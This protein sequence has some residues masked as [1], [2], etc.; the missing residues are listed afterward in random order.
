MNRITLNSLSVCA[1]LAA[2]TSPQHAFAQ[3]DVAGASPN[4]LLLVDT[5]GSMEYLTSTATPPVCDP[6]SAV[7][8]QK[9]RWVNLVEVLT[10]SINDYRCV[11]ID[12]ASS[13]FVSTFSLA[14]N[15]PADY[16]YS[17]PYHQP[18]SGNCVAGPGTI[19]L[20]NNAFAISDGAGGTR[21]GFHQYGN[22][23]SCTFSQNTSDGLLS[24]YSSNVRFGLMTFD[25]STN[26]G[27]GFS[28]QAANYTTGIAGTWSY[29]VNNP[30]QGRPGGCPTLV[31]YEVGARNAAA[32]PWEGRMVAFGDPSPNSS[33]P[34]DNPTARAQWISEILLTT[35]PFTQPRLPA[36]STT[37]APFFGM[38]TQKI[39]WTRPALRTLALT[40]ILICSAAAV[41]TSS[42]Y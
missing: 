2:L 16:N 28:G 42:F 15:R 19:N 7:N 23:N 18:I 22:T 3:S 39:R 40:M 21:I 26:A 27:T 6:N 10:G 4:V 9:S 33:D 31:D 5:S 13:G 25:T 37:H 32:P 30:T 20:T 11:T 1:L 35:R 41:R 24:T 36:C 14:G 17:I 29:F 8:S 12:R 34:N 38:T